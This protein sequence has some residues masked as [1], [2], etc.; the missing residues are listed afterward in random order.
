[1]SILFSLC[2]FMTMLIEVHDGRK[3][4]KHIILTPNLIV[5]STIYLFSGF[6]TTP[7]SLWQLN[8]CALCCKLLNK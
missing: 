1:M 3:I 8:L 5:F 6:R 4:F 2:V 7:S